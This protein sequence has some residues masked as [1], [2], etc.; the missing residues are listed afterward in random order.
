[1]AVDEAGLRTVLEAARGGVVFEVGRDRVL[2]GALGG[3]VDVTDLR[4]GLG[5]CRVGVVGVDGLGRP[6]DGARGE[7]VV[8]AEGRGRALGRA[9][10]GGVV[11]VDGRGNVLGDT[12]D[13]GGGVVVEVRLPEAVAGMETGAVSVADSEASVD[14]LESE[15]V[16]V[17]LVDAKVSIVAAVDGDAGWIAEPLLGTAGIR[18]V[19][20]E[21]SA[22]DAEGVV[23]GAADGTNGAAVGMRLV[24][25]GGPTTEAVGAVVEATDGPNLVAVKNG[26]VEVG[27]QS[28]KGVRGLVASEA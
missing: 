1:M 26:F 28:P 12:G 16:R 24:E 20:A 18:P 14:G 6:P 2:D 13:E 11:G 19:E 3:T 22:Y 27:S 21:A 10:R 23:E 17:R 4:R 8:D 7:G 15:P 9:L 25:A 5:V